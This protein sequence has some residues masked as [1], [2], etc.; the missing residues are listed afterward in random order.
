LVQFIV[1]EREFMFAE[2]IIKCQIIFKGEI[3][4]KKN[5][6]LFPASKAKKLG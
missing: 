3:R 6:V 2:I 1:K 4:P 5:I